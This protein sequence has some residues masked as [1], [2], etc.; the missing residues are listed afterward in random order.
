[1][2]KQMKLV[3]PHVKKNILV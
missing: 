2:H 1:M 3:C